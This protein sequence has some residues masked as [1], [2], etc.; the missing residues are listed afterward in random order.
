MKNVYLNLVFVFLNLAILSFCIGFLFG[1]KTA[2]YEKDKEAIENG[3]AEW[4]VTVE[5]NGKVH[6]EFKWIKK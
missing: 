1:V 2:A 6:K 5:P 4:T 3:A